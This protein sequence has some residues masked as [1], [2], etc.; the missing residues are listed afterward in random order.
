MTEVERTIYQ[1]LV[2]LWSTCNER[3]GYAYLRWHVRSRGVMITNAKLD[4]VLQRL[5][6]QRLI[7]MEDDQITWVSRLAAR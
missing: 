6:E 2:D 5:L 4:E 7:Q 1:E 3:I